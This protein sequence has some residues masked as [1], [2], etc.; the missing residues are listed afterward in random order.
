[1]FQ[2]IIALIV[3]FFFLSRLG[4]QLWHNQIPRGQFFFWLCF[5]LVSGV[6]VI[7]LRQVDAL[8]AR[9][10]FSSSGIELLLY[11]AVIMIFYFIFRIRL[12]LEQIE[13]HITQLT[14]EQA[15]QN[16]KGHPRGE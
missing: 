5:W 15:W 11:I 14:R 6:L 3:I 16:A 4:W 9:L 8:A 2:E 10:G 12:K 1:M 13:K 7:F